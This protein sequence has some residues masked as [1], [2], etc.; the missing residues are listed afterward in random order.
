[1]I[2]N[3]LWVCWGSGV[4]EFLERRWK[5][6]VYFGFCSLMPEPTQPL[7]LLIIQRKKKRSIFSVYFFSRTKRIAMIA[8][9]NAAITMPRRSVES[10]PVLS[11]AEPT[12]R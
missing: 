4:G 8:M 9:I 5:N 12:I 10:E 6:F 7:S 1:M 2:D 3:V 11:D